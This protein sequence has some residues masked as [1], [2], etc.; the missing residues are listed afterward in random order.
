MHWLHTGI[1]H[2][3]FWSL[4]WLS[5][6]DHPFLHM[7]FWPASLQLHSSGTL[8]V[9][10][11]H[12]ESFV[13]WSQISA[14][15]SDFKFNLI[16]IFLRN[17]DILAIYLMLLIN[18]PFASM[19]EIFITSDLI[20]LPPHWTWPACSIFRTK[21]WNL[22]RNIPWHSCGAIVS[23][24]WTL[25]VLFRISSEVTSSFENEGIKKLKI[26]IWY[27]G[28][29]ATVVKWDHGK[30]S[31]IQVTIVHEH[32]SSRWYW[33]D[34]AIVNLGPVLADKEVLIFFSVMTVDICPPTLFFIWSEEK[35]KNFLR[36]FHKTLHDGTTVGSE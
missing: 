1:E 26:Q 12:P 13:H 35:Q 14:S 8:H 7:T 20:K 31:C 36:F 17:Q 23:C 11:I 9:P 28:G 5:D 34:Q 15:C 19:C 29:P 27:F 25:I 2:G 24:N 33:P 22:E 18:L 21:P 4:I 3:S 30:A 6:F 10:S 32:L 16:F